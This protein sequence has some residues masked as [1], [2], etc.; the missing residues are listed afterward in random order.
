MRMALQRR[1]DAGKRELLS[2]RFFEAHDA[3]ERVWRRSSGAER[4]LGGSKGTHELF[5]QSNLPGETGDDLFCVEAQRRIEFC[6]CGV[7]RFAEGLH[8]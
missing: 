3:F 2:G 1:L 7:N 6:F 4:D 8:L 5:L